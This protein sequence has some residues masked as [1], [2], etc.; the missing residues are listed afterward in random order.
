[1]QFR[2]GN[3]AVLRLL[4]QFV[5][6]KKTEANSPVKGAVI[7][8]LKKKRGLNSPVYPPFSLPITFSTF[9]PL[10]HCPS[11]PL[12]P[13]LSVGSNFTLSP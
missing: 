2:I 7:R 9:L 4:Q 6:M 11:P 5:E 8:R 12:P 3:D 10:W 1:V 13:A